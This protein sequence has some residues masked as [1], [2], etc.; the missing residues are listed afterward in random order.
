VYHINVNDGHR[1]ILRHHPFV[2]AVADAL[3]RRCGVEPG[4][5]ILVAV[6]GG[7]DSTALLHALAAVAP[8]REWR[9]DLHVAHVHHHLREQADED[10]AFVA[11]TAGSL[12]LPLHRDDIRPADEPGNLED[13]ARRMRYEALGRIAGSIEAD[14][15]AAA[16][17]ADDQLETML[18][19]LSRGA[20]PGGLAARPPRR[21]FRDGPVLVRPMLWTDRAAAV[22]LLQEIG[23]DWCEDPSNADLSRW[24]ARLRAEV[25]P[26]LRE[27]RSD[28]SVKAAEAAD[29]VREA[30]RLIR[31]LARRAERRSLQ[32]VSEDEAVMERDAARRLPEPVL[33]AVLRRPCRRLGVGA[34][35]L[36]R[37]AVE[38]ILRAVRAADGETRRFDLAGGVRVEV[39]PERIRWARRG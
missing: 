9:L 25:L 16:H 6:S 12:G 18:M 19:R 26:V 20:A 22:A 28:A 3:H 11:R 27:L 38:P 36:G 10:A 23:S 24:R 15:I 21:R 1:I 5:R 8:Q 30:D 34:D 32:W 31:R 7:A 29:R 39:G 37:R 35:A 2:K 13:N 17:Q 33:F 4:M 14:A